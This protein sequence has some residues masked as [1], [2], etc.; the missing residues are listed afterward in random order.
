LRHRKLLVAI[1]AMTLVA[2]GGCAGPPRPG[3]PVD[4]DR[5]EVLVG[6]AMSGMATGPIRAAGAGRLAVAGETHDFTFAVLY[7]PPGW[8]RADARPPLAL[9]PGPSGVSAVLVGDRLTAQLPS[10]SWLVG[11]LRDAL[12]GIEWTDPGS[13]VVG[14]PDLRFL[15]RLRHAR[16]ERTGSELV[17][18]GD[19]FGRRVE[20]AIDTASFSVTRIALRDRRDSTVAVSYAGHGWNRDAGMP[21]TVVVTYADGARA[22][23]LALTYGRAASEG[24]VDRRGLAID[25]PAGAPVLRWKD[26]ESWRRP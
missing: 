8:L 9:A 6:R 19:L 10:G 12:P 26:L 20:A 22:D 21:R 25:A 1:A 24:F 14:R 23:T 4:P 17:V 11:D 16:I 2:A 5:L 3:V 15:T 13:F 18:S 7:D